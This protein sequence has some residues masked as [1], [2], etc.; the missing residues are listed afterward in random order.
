MSFARLK[1]RRWLLLFTA[2][3]L[4]F[5]LVTGCDGE[6]EKA[7][8][9]L[10]DAQWESLWIVNAIA[11]YIITEGYGY[12]VEILQ[13][14]TPLARQALASGDVHI[15][16]EL[17]QQNWVDYYEEQV[18]AGNIENLGVTYEG[19]PQFWVIPEW[20]HEEYDINTVDDMK[21]YWELFEDPADPTKG[22]F[23]NCFVGWACAGINDVKM[24][25]YGLTDYYNILTPGSTG[26]EDAALESA[27]LTEEPV[28]GYYWSPTQ[29]ME[30]YDWYILVEPEYDADVWDDIMA[31]IDDPTLRPVSAACAYEV[32]DV[33]KGI[34]P[35][36]RDIAPDVVEMLEVMNVGMWPLYAVTN[37]YNENELDDYK[38]AALYFLE[39]YE[40][41]WSTWVTDEAYDNIK[42]ALA[43]E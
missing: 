38:E 10:A 8:I 27:Q 31:A 13:T 26:A 15:H 4:I 30:M 36:L 22:L 14:T 28:F 20:V 16:M 1:W 3:V 23:I 43:A 2:L 37:W 39:N 19:G 34:N 7:T 41:V 24:E 42:D 9:I 12:P 17:W 6:E 11:E 32:L 40:D 33:E 21:D 18:A 35:S 5:P 29:L 25:A